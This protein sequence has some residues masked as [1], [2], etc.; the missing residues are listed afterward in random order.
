MPSTSIKQAKQETIQNFLKGMLGGAFTKSDIVDYD[1]MPAISKYLIEAANVFLFTAT[2]ELDK[3][4][5]NVS[6]TL[7]SDLSVSQVTEDGNTYSITVGYP[8]TSPASKYYDYVN[9]GVQG[10]ESG[11]PAD[12][13]YWFKNPFPN[14][15]MAA[16]LFT[17]INTNRKLSLKEQQSQPKKLSKTQK[18]RESLKKMVSEATNK[19]RLAYAM[20]TSI[21]KKGI[22]ASKYMDIAQDVAFGKEFIQGLADIA[23]GS[24]IVLLKSAATELND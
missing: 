21:K 13:P 15:V 7:S 18:K 3:Q 8:P 19:R 2:K 5:K 14:R 16:A 1:N 10:F 9:K 11:T 12:S 4:G 20:A 22:K 23:A 6:G 24:T 17:W